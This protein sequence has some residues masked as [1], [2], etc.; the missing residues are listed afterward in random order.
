MTPPA[1]FLG[2]TAL[3]FAASGV[4]ALFAPAA[5]LEGVGVVLA[6][7]SVLIELRAMYGGGC[8]GIAALLAWCLPR[9]RQRT[10]LTAVALIVGGI[11]AGRL[12]GLLWEP[13]PSAVA[14]LAAGEAVWTALAL[15]LLVRAPGKP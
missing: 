13:A 4:A 5:L 2:L 1:L 15:G 7:D 3:V 8:L 14:W 6:P 12:L 11:L 9:A 10:G